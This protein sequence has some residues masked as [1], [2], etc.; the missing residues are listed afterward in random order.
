MADCTPFKQAGVAQGFAMGD[1]PVFGS[2]NIV[3]W[4]PQTATCSPG[5]SAI[6][7]EVT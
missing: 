7:C 3:P 1:G 6:S 5:L 2:G 4:W